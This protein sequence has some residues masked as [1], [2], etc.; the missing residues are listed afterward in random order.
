M[1]DINVELCDLPPGSN[2]RRSRKPYRRVI[3]E[4][5]NGGAGKKMS[6][7]IEPVELAAGI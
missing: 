6:L 7:N 1:Q 4:V 5:T 3:A 2:L